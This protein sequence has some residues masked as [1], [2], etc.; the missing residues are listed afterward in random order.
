[1]ANRY[2]SRTTTFSPEGHLYQVEYAITAIQNAAAAVGIL[3]EQGIVI[4]GQKKTGSKLLAPPKTSEKL[5][6][7]DTHVAAAVAGL[8]SDADILVDYARLTAQRYRYRYD[9]PMPV[10]QLVKTLC[11]QK[12]SYTQFGGLRPFGVSFLFAGWDQYLGF[13]LY[14]SNPSGNYS[15]WK[16][17]AIGANSTSSQSTLKTDYK[18]DMTL[19]EAQGLAVKVLTK[20]MDTTAP[21]SEQVEVSTVFLH[22]GQ[23]VQKVLSAEET[24]VLIKEATEAAAEEGE[25]AK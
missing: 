6:K 23:V 3:T 9:E 22:E 21:S 11:N 20:A 12:H 1:M 10:E 5:Y 15:G 8:T 17:T 13:Q 2:D 14:Q 7:L 24:D 16:A 25:E 19:A 4:A 18:A